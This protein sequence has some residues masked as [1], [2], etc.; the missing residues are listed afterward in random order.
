MVCV[1]CVCVW[2]GEGGGREGGGTY[3]NRDFHQ[4]DYCHVV[5]GEE[6]WGVREERGGGEE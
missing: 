1:V 6:L 3:L 5:E 2:R 4:N